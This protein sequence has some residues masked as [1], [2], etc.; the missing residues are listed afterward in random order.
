VLKVH[1]TPQ[2]TQS[3]PQMH[4]NVP[5]PQYLYV[6]PRLKLK[7][8]SNPNSSK[9]ILFAK[10]R[11]TL[12]FPQNRKVQLV[13]LFSVH[14]RV[15]PFSDQPQKIQF[16]KK[17]PS[18]LQLTHNSAHLVVPFIK[19]LRTDLI[20]FVTRSNITHLLISFFIQ[21]PFSHKFLKLS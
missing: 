2:L 1:K 17:F 19:G 7:K 4:T 10:Q 13:T 18:F 20:L 21:D 11:E 8:T 15:F 16:P 3:S 5:P 9:K 12:K 14:L 6:D